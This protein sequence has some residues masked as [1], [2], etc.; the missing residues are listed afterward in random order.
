MTA[1]HFGRFDIM[2]I[3]KYLGIVSTPVYC[4]KIA[5]KLVRTFTDKHGLKELAKELANIDL[6]KQQQFDQEE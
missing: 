2:M 6:N 1:L 4:T 5:S 3:E